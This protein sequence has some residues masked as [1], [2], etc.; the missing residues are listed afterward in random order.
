MDRKHLVDA[1]ENETKEKV[2]GITW[3]YGIGYD[4]VGDGEVLYHYDVA[5]QI[6]L[7]SGKYISV[8]ADNYCTDRSR[9]IESTIGSYEFNNVY[10]DLGDIDDDLVSTLLDY[11]EIYGD[12]LEKPKLDH[13]YFES[14]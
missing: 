13:V 6:D 2:K 8:S 4:N 1:V 7:S 12:E 5:L 9:V 14:M 3:I 11:I 10:S